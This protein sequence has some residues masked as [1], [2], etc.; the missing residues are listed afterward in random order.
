MA[1]PSLTGC[2]FDEKLLSSKHNRITLRRQP[3]LLCDYG[4][5]E[6]WSVFSYEILKKHRVLGRAGLPLLRSFCVL[7]EI[8]L[9]TQSF[10]LVVD[11]VVCEVLRF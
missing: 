6:G 3:H 8:L 5:G 4:L 1:S 11:F 9:K 7:C 10:E 2:F